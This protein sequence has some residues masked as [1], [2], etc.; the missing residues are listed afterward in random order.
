MIISPWFFQVIF[1]R[2][3]EKSKL[4]T[5]DEEK[6]RIRLFSFSKRHINITG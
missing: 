5:E 2:Y 1:G 3:G 4:I 6:T